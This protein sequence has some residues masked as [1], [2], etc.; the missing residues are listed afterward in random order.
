MVEGPPTNETS[1]NES[2][3]KEPVYVRPEWYEAW[4]EGNLRVPLSDRG[5]HFFILN[6]L[7]TADADTFGEV[8]QEFRDSELTD[9]QREAM[10]VTFMRSHA[11]NR[12]GVGVEGADDET[13]QSFDKILARSGFEGDVRNV[14]PERFT[15]FWK[16]IKLGTLD[17]VYFWCRNLSFQYEESNDADREVFGNVTSTKSLIAEWNNIRPETREHLMQDLRAFMHTNL[18]ILRSDEMAKFQR[19]QKR[20]IR[21]RDPDMNM[22]E[23]E[24]F[25]DELDERVEKYLRREYATRCPEL[26]GRMVPSSRGPIIM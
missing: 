22:A 1:A 10:I 13:R 8:L 20:I 11:A 3:E 6:E 9:E 15:K 18:E 7:V 16:A 12:V 25:A 24:S 4:D 26:Y 19:E 17:P 21:E 14:G 5:I 23:R 2:Q